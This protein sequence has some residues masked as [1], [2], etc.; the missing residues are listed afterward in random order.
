MASLIVRGG[1]RLSGHIA[2]DG[3]TLIPG[4]NL[5]GGINGA[6]TSVQETAYTN[7]SASAT[8]TTQYTMDRDLDTLCIQNPPNAGTQT[9]CLPL[10]Q[11]IDAVLGFDIP[12]GIEPTAPMLPKISSRF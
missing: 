9:Q 1:R 11:R 2:V 4:I 8:V 7:N 12:P 6:T 3:N 10:V 5:D